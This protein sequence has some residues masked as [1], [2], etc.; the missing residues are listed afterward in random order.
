MS[1]LD[2]FL[3][4]VGQVLGGARDSFG[5][6]SA[7]AGMSFRT[8]GGGVV[9]PQDFSSDSGRA[10]DAHRQAVAQSGNYVR[11]LDAE[12]KASAPQAP[13]AIG[14]AAAGRA[15]IDAAIAG[16]VADVGSTPNTEAGRKVL[17]DRILAR[18]G[19][20]KGALADGE[21]D[22]KSRA[23]EATKSAAN[24]NAIGRPGA[25]GAMPTGMGAMPFGGMPMGGGGGGMPGMGGGGMPSIPGLSALSGLGSLAQLGGLNPAQALGGMASA[26]SAG[27]GA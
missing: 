16:A 17:V 27:A 14:A 7:A 8:G 10:S 9:V 20:A 5:Q 24:Y 18:L 12:D 4:S 15:R 3:M 13:N 11:M 2:S 22:S 21:A 26:T 23:A 25:V 6:P 1:S 19:D